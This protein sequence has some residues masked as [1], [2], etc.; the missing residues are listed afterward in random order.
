MAYVYLGAYLL[1]NDFERFWANIA[2]GKSIIYTSDRMHGRFVCEGMR[3]LGANKWMVKRR[4][5]KENILFIDPSS[6]FNPTRSHIED[7]APPKLRWNLDIIP[8]IENIKE[9]FGD[10]RERSEDIRDK[11]AGVLSRWDFRED[12]S[13]NCEGNLEIDRRWLA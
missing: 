11:S 1:C 8:V 12:F 13:R 5:R 2:D 7:Y 3:K 10:M 9:M 4:F 6:M